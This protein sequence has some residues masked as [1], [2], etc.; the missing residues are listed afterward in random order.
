MTA[1]REL[2]PALS[3]G[4]GLSFVALVT[5]FPGR[6]GADSLRSALPPVETIRYDRMI[7]PAGPRIDGDKQ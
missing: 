1:R 5:A 4:P 6:N 3:R 2:L 7:G